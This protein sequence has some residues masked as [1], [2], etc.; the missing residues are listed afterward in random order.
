VIAWSIAVAIAP[1]PSVDEPVSDDPT[2]PAIDAP[3]EPAPAEP[4]AP[5]P[6]S[7]SA[8][9]RSV[10]APDPAAVPGRE[11]LRPPNPTWHV[12]PPRGRVLIDATASPRPTDVKSRPVHGEARLGLGFGA[13]MRDGIAQ[14]W[15][16]VA[17]DFSERAPVRLGVGFPIR[18]RMVPQAPDQSGVVRRRDVDE[19]G[20]F[21]AIL[22][23]LSYRDQFARGTEGRAEVDLQIGRVADES[24][25]HGSLVRHVHGN[26]DLDRRRTGVVFRSALRGR[27]AQQHAAFVTEV[28]APDPTGGH[29]LGAR[30]AGELAGAGL[31]LQVAGDPTA[32]RQL[33]TTGTTTVGWARDD[34]TG[35]LRSLGRR[36]VV[37]TAL[38]LS[39]RATDDWSWTV[40]PYVDLVLLPGLGGGGHI[41]VAPEGVLGRRRRIRLGGMAEVTA[42]S[43]G[44]DPAYFD[45]TYGV[46]RWQVPPLPVRGA[47]PED[48]VD[49]SAPK[50]GFVA[51][52]NL[53]GAGGSGR[54]YLRHGVGVAVE[55]GYRARP[56]PRG[57][58]A[59]AAFGITLPAVD[60]RLRAA[61][62]GRHGFEAT[63]RGTV[64]LLEL[65][66]PI[67]RYLEFEASAGWLF[68]LR[69]D[70]DVPGA[71]VL[72]GAGFFV[73]GVAGRVP[74]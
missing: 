57:H 13:V 47:R 34:R 53:R 16:R 51:G 18:F 66:V 72:A 35:R 19:A 44:Y 2:V 1:L 22:E 32:P 69:A 70:P 41:G 6:L 27:V 10:P 61:H 17:L 74:W 21:V 25:G 23:H 54:V 15:P 37:G 67:L 45:L 55:L 42:G 31:G 60:L 11:R 36:G 43:T 4:A 49:T 40:L 58:L 48:L 73:A 8:A 71:G 52:E 24:L 29:V 39:Y 62:R 56:G 64:G 46:D 26:L 30:V 65:R 63:R 20:D 7:T 59:D 12:V 5:S 9:P 68:A 33:A 38:D 14:L 3:A 28:V 50:H